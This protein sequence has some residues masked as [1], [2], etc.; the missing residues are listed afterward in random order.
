MG[1]DGEGVLA[2]VPGQVV[3]EFDDVLVQAVGARIL[4]GAG[5]EAVAAGYGDVH[6]REEDVAGGAVVAD[7][8]VV[9]GQF[10]EQVV[11]QGAVELGDGG[12][13]LVVQLVI[14][15]SEGENGA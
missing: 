9:Q 5:G 4:L 10:V 15:V 2:L 11:A 3:G 13:G 6:L 14:N 12:V 7:G 8:G 1:A